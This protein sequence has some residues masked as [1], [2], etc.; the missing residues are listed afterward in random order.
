MSLDFKRPK[1]HELCGKSLED[2]TRDTITTRMSNNNNNHKKESK[3]PQFIINSSSLTM[4][5]LTSS[6]F[7]THTMKALRSRQTVKV[8]ASACIK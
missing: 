3:T 2:S 1:A 6:T 5:A 4:I 8:T 7:S